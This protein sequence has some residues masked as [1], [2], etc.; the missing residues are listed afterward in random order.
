LLGLSLLVGS[1]YSMAGHFNASRVGQPFGNAMVLAPRGPVRGVVV[2]MGDHTR[3]EADEYAVAQAMARRGLLVGLVPASPSLVTAAAGGCDRLQ[4]DVGH[5]A[6]RLMRRV[7]VDNAYFAP[8]VVGM[9]AAGRRLAMLTAAGAA[10]GS[11][12]GVLLVGAGPA[13]ARQDSPGCGA[14]VGTGWV[15]LR[16]HVPDTIA[17]EVALHLPAPVPRFRD[18]PLVELHAPGSHRL[19]ILMSGDGGW[20]ALD[21]GLAARLRADGN[22]VL[23]WDSLRYF[24]AARTPA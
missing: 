11:L 8:M 13:G 6:R 19:V 15:Q 22:S 14:S 23:G 12:G 7:D 16:Q 18:L 4:D 5:V 3:R 1:G 17:A 24:W 21:G 20:R 2:L 9:G 10:P